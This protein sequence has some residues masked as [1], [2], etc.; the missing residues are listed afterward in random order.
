MH[1]GCYIDGEWVQPRSER[2]LKNV[3]PSNT[4]DVIAEFPAATPNEVERAVA[5]AQKAFERW[6]R[7][8]APERARVVWRATEIAR[9]RADELARM[10]AREEGKVLKEAQGEIKKGNSILEFYAGEG[11]R[12]QGRTLPSEVADVFTYTIRRPLGVVGLITPWNF[13]YAIPC[14]KIAPALVAGNTCVFKPAGLTPGTAAILVEV[15]E[16]AGLPPGCLQMVVGPGS[17]VGDAIVRHPAIQAISFTG[18]TPV[19]LGLNALAAERGAKVTCEMGGKNAVVALPG[20]DVDNVVASVL[21]GAFG[22][23]GQR[24][25]ATS[26]LLV[27]EELRAQVTEALVEGARAIRVGDALEEGSQMGPAV[28]ARQFQTDLEYIAVGKQE[29]RLLTG[30]GRPAGLEGGYFVEPTIFTEVE[31]E[32]R[33]FREEIFGPVLSICPIK[34]LEDGIAKANAVEFGL[35]ASIYT[36]DIGQAM[37]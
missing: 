9:R 8:P 30:G 27:H 18:S 31:P 6:R 35:T 36:P 5:G 19:G 22:S 4:E 13:P 33:I 29:A 25:T 26:R 12:I 1:T 28:D 7:V 21:N 34:D 17:T 11:F 23:T 32:H 24:C 15:F 2:I 3:N 37:R 10:L 20:A 14:W 16:E